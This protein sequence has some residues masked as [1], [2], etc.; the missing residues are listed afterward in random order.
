METILIMAKA[1]EKA[2]KNMS[3]DTLDMQYNTISDDYTGY[4]TLTWVD[5]GEWNRDIQ[6]KYVIKTDGTVTRLQE[7]DND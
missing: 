7:K 4:V 1:L 2:S 5:H 6:S 3:I